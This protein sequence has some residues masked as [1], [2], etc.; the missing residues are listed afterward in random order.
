MVRSLRGSILLIT[1]GG[2]N[3]MVV[4]AIVGAVRDE[5]LPLQEEQSGD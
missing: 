2:E 3:C 5:F 4:L 1:G